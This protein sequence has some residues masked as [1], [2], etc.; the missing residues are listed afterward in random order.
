MA[1][2]STVRKRRKNPRGRPAI[3]RPLSEII[4]ARCSPEE[5]QIIEDGARQRGWSVSKWIRVAL[6]TASPPVVSVD[7]AKQRVEYS[8]DAEDMADYERRFMES[9]AAIDREDADRQRLAK[10]VQGS[11]R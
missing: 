3:T 5:R 1:N 8:E 11:K 4:I 2:T 7:L 6:R 9:A 10:H